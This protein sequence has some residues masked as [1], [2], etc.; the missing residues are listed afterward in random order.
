MRGWKR[1]APKPRKET[2]RERA[3]RVLKEEEARRKPKRARAPLITP[4][5]SSAHMLL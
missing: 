2:L 3:M 4:L 5:D 1:K